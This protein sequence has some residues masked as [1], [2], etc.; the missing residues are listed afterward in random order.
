MR[1]SAK[2]MTALPIIIE[3]TLPTQISF[4]PRHLSEG[5]SRQASNIS[6]DLYKVIKSQ[7]SRHF[8][9]FL[10]YRFSVFLSIILTHSL[11]K[12]IFTV[13]SVHTRWI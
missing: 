6:K 1:F 12:Y 8:S 10:Y 4:T 3:N 9:D 11:C 13:I 2:C 5:I 7:F